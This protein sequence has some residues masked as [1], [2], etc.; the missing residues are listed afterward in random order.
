MIAMGRES[1]RSRGYSSEVSNCNLPCRLADRY[2]R[3]RFKLEALAGQVNV[4][5]MPQQRRVFQKEMFR[6][7]VVNRLSRKNFER[8]LIDDLAVKDPF[9]LAKIRKAENFWRH[10]HLHGL[11]RFKTFSLAAS[12]VGGNGNTGTAGGGCPSRVSYPA[13]QPQSALAVPRVRSSAPARR[14]WDQRAGMRR[15]RTRARRGRFD[16]P[17]IG[18]GKP[19]SRPG[20]RKSRLRPLE[21]GNLPSWRS[22][23]WDFVSPATPRAQNVASRSLACRVGSSTIPPNGSAARSSSRRAGGCGSLA[24]MRGRASG[25]SGAIRARRN[26]D[27]HGPL[28][29]MPRPRGGQGQPR[30]ADHDVTISRRRERRGLVPGSAK[31]SPLFAR[32]NDHSMPPEGELPLTPAQIDVVRRWV[33]AGTPAADNGTTPENET[34]AAEVSAA[35]R[36]YWAFRKLAPQSPPSVHGADRIRTPMDAVSLGKARGC[37]NLVRC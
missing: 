7:D 15:L 4:W 3:H 17:A 22:I 37:G 29:E 32:V 21:W 8:P 30:P 23:A 1:S 25:R 36:D 34:P 5:P 6:S 27:F 18:E 10:R 35:D 20:S 9:Y 2:V 24:G 28:S 19:L 13:T 12:A 16:R 11:R 14:S 31:D 26:A 33:D